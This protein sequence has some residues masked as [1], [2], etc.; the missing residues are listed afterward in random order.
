MIER[1]LAFPDWV[2]NML[3][4]LV[5]LEPGE[6]AILLSK[7]PHGATWRIAKLGKAE[8]ALD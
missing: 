7:G 4:R 6:Y 8:N 1:S 3:S 5:S 2:L